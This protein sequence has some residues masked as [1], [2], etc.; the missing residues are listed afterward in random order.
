MDVIKMDRL[1]DAINNIGKTQ[2]TIVKNLKR[3]AS[4]RDDLYRITCGHDFISRLERV[5][6]HIS[7]DMA[8]TAKGFTFWQEG[9]RNNAVKE[10]IFGSWVVIDPTVKFYDI[11]ILAGDDY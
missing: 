6:V 10:T 3:L 7:P 2:K 8:A 5:E 4:L 9:K 11:R 1:D